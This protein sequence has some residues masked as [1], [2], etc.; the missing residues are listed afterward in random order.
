[1]VQDRDLRT[2][3]K[4]ASDK[5][6]NKALQIQRREEH[7]G[8]K[9]NSVNKKVVDSLD[10]A[11]EEAAKVYAN[12]V[13]NMKR[14]HGQLHH[15]GVASEGSGHRFNTVMGLGDSVRAVSILGEYS[16]DLSKGARKLRYAMEGLTLADAVNDLMNYNMPDVHIMSRVDSADAEK[17]LK[18]AEKEVKRRQEN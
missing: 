8:G 11:N 12:E 3:A 16:Y 17:I 5:L 4:K 14:F 9:I 2:M 13:G 18:E 6:L 10:E 15:V 1:M 7:L